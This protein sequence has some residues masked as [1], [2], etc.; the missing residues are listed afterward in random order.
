M[1]RGPKGIPF[2]HEPYPKEYV[3]ETLAVTPK[4]CDRLFFHFGLILGIKI[5]LQKGFL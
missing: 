2:D 1:G 5:V 3:G 4:K